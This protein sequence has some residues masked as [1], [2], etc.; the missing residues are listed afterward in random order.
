[1]SKHLHGLRAET[2]LLLLA[3]VAMGILMFF[4]LRMLGSY[5]VD[6]ILKT[7]GYIEREEQKS[8][9]SLQY[10]ISSYQV[11]A[12]DYA[13]LDA[14]TEREGVV[15]IAVFRDS[16]LLYDSAEATQIDNDGQKN[17]Y[18]GDAHIYSV[19]F[20]DGTADVYLLGFYSYRYENWILLVSA[21]LAA[22]TA[23]LFFTIILQKKINYI[24]QLENEVRILETGGLSHAVTVKGKDEIAALA[25]GLN[26]MRISLSNNFEMVQKLTDANTNLVTELSHD[27][28]TPLTALLLYLQLLQKGKY[29]D[30]KTLLQYLQKASEKAEEV[31]AMSDDLFERFLISGQKEEKLEAPQEIRYVFEDP[32]SDLI[33]FLQTQ[34]FSADCRTEWPKGKISVS[35]DYISR[36]F[37]NISSNILKYASREQPVGISLREAEGKLS[38]SFMNRKDRNADRSDSTKIGLPNI[39]LMMQ[40]MNGECEIREDHDSFRII[41]SFPVYAEESS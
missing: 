9:D 22:G 24:K 34:G 12:T 29:K 20:A 37:D 27:L 3:S 14:W 32:L 28:R 36:I 38:L 7:S 40:K 19:S 26:E 1:M 23:L 31:K 11:S 30:E 2:L 18:Y 6:N 35:T 10:F 33:M 15:Y 21:A 39:Q 5:L 13:M 16:T 41:L 17:G 4:G 8:A 25:T